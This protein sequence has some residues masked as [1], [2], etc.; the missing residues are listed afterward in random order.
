MMIGAQKKD[1]RLRSSE[2]R[3]AAAAPSEVMQ[4]PTMP[5]SSFAW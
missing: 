4:Y 5:D 2:Y 3:L 1:E